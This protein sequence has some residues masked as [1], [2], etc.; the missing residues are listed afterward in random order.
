M[1]YKPLEELE[2]IN[3]DCRIQ[4]TK[5]LA[6]HH[7]VRTIGGP[8]EE[9]QDR[10]R[11]LAFFVAYEPWETSLRCPPG[12]ARFFDL[13]EKYDLLTPQEANELS[14]TLIR[15]G[16]EMA[17]AYNGAFSPFFS[18]PRIRTIFN[19][20]DNLQHLSESALAIGGSWA[21]RL[22][23][24][25]PIPLQP[26]R[27]LEVQSFRQI[28]IEEE[29]EF[30]SQ[31]PWL[32][33]VEALDL[34]CLCSWAGLKP[35]FVTKMVQALQQKVVRVSMEPIDLPDR[36]FGRKVV[37]PMFSRGLQGAVVGLFT[38]VPKDEMEPI[39]TSLMQFGETLSDVYADLRWRN[40]VEALENELD[41]HELAREVI[42]AVSPIA[43]IIVTIDGRKAG[44]K[45]RSECNYW[46]GFEPLTNAEIAG[47]RSPRGFSVIGPGGSDIYIEPLADTPHIHPHFTKVRLENYLNQVFGAIA[48]APD[49]EALSLKEIQQLFAE[50]AA[51][52]ADQAA[53]LA[54]LRQYYVISKV[55]KNWANG[56]VK[57]T[58]SELKRFFEERGRDAKTG[59]QV[60]SFAAEVEKIFAG[61]IA[62]AKT[63]NALSLSWRRV[64]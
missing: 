25:S 36:V 30:Y 56:E 15:H 62:A 54:K 19:N 41:E 20:V 14:Q 32:A 10:C 61:K 53:S 33:W 31:T 46:C 9:T 22:Y 49:G 13:A 12:S 11:G 58:N 34:I 42:N 39:L 6:E 48:V 52:A 35:S 57:V 27:H 40:F 43:K 18:S 24:N 51:Y 55:E 60:T 4:L 47:P 28:T 2:E 26:E 50:Y 8:G 63:R 29:I 38:D 16:V 23:E 7:R 45:I 44:Y 21:D 1:V 3:T 17:R 59:Y 5:T 64:D 37:L